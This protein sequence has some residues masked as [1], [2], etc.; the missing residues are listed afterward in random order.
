MKITFGLNLN[1]AEWS[2][3]PAA[4]GE[5]RFC[6]EGMLSF[7]QTRLG[8]GGN[9]E[10]AV[11]RI[12]QYR[13]RLAAVISAS[14]DAGT[15]SGDGWFQKSFELDPWSTA[16][17]L[18]SWRDELILAGWNRPAL[19]A[20]HSK[21]LAVLSVIEGRTEPLAQGTADKLRE[22]LDELDTFDASCIQSIELA[23][24]LELLPHLWQLVFNKLGAMGVPIK[25]APLQAP[26]TLLEDSLVLL[27]ADTEWEAA[28]ALAMWL[29]ADEDAN[30]K[31]NMIV[32]G[33][34]GVLGTA[35]H[36]LGL[37]R[38]GSSESS[39][40]RA[41]LQILPLVFANAW[42]PIELGA[43]VALLTLPISPVPSDVRYWLLRALNNEAGVKGE[44][45]NE[46]L[47]EIAKQYAAPKDPAYKAKTEKEIDEILKTIDNMLV[48]GRYPA[49]GIPEAAI[50]E[51]CNWIIKSLTPQCENYNFLNAP[52]GQAGTLKRMVTG[53]G[54]IG[55]IELERMIDL[56]V[57][58]ESAEVKA[59]AAPWKAA[60]HPGGVTASRPYL[61]WWNFINQ[62][63]PKTTYWNPAEREAL[64]RA[65]IVLDEPGMAQKREVFAWNNA[66]LKAPEKAIL[67]RSKKL[68][69][70]D[71]AR[72]PFWDMIVALADKKWGENTAK[73]FI[74]TVNDVFFTHEQWELS[75]RTGKT[76]E[77][78]LFVL[79]QGQ[80]EYRIPGQ[81]VKV[82]KTS[83]SDMNTLI[84]CP[85]KWVMEKV[86]KIWP[87]DAASIPDINKSIGTLCH[88]IIQDIF[89]HSKR[90]WTPPEARKEAERLFDEK[91]ESM[92][93]ELCAEGKKIERA[94]YRHDI[95]RAV[96]GLNELLEK[97]K[98][99][100]EKAEAEFSGSLGEV[101]FKGFV[102]LILRDKE[103][104]PV[105]MDLKWTRSADKYRRR[106]IEESRDLQLASY[107]WLIEGQQPDAKI[108]AGYFLMPNNTWLPD[109]Q[110]N[111]RKVFANAT[112]TWQGELQKL[113]EGVVAKGHDREEEKEED[114]ETSTETFKLDAPCNLCQYEGLCKIDEGAAQ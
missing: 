77:T 18:L 27:E 113:A 53:R 114:D 62:G 8:L 36:R 70:E 39:K 66:F 24:P 69:G 56:L 11:V 45:W 61:I 40:W 1:N 57:A 112:N 71:T 20:D 102:D 111:L 37:P 19:P 51:R 99:T 63:A 54:T 41:H 55:R 108:N 25:E 72:H 68:R 4:L 93:V 98:F 88:R 79:P 35:L 64:R 92:V 81:R 89:V 104:N 5:I 34:S 109:N 16:K 33:A 59:E 97:E 47:E 65:G 58:E 67:I 30:K 78:P 38:T 74:R 28:E 9:D 83:Y 75:G 17:Q 107:A 84:G 85:L 43:L 100:V 46:S 13:R 105:V 7:L 6:P 101:P 91:A 95:G 48:T 86:V 50:I 96:Y 42:Q 14:A 31:L 80:N 60:S 10:P 21:R 32:P 15:A 22:V 26:I 73:K 2:E 3:N 90:S 87:S 110:K 52:I 82:E 44:E 12:D 49:G 103:H 106:E 76:I 94:R 23:E 29:A